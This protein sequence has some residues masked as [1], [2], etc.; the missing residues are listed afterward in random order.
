[1]A[2]PSKKPKPNLRQE[3][4]K[5]NKILASEGLGRQPKQ[6]PPWH[7]AST[8]AAIKMLSGRNSNITVRLPSDDPR[9]PNYADR[10]LISA[11]NRQTA[12]AIN[13][14]LSDWVW[15]K[16]DWSQH[17]ENDRR[18][19]ELHVVEGWFAERISEEL[20][21]NWRWVARILAKHRTL[22]GVPKT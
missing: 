21:L 7:L 12:D 6:I 15:R 22:A 2:I 18:V 20:S 10:V 5:W 13:T 16:C 11:T 8:G 14:M 1:V 17:S 19:M 3:M 9:N 4:A